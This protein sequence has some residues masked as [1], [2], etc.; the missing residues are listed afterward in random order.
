MRG[1]STNDR[2]KAA[3]WFKGSERQ[4]GDLTHESRKD[5]AFAGC[6]CEAAY[7]TWP[8]PVDCVHVG[9]Q[10]RRG[11]KKPLIMTNRIL[12]YEMESGWLRFSKDSGEGRT[13]LGRLVRA[14][15]NRALETG[16]YDPWD[17]PGGWQAIVATG[18][19]G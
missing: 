16:I 8:G 6:G 13:H 10:I 9:C 15:R 18:V 5:L 19:H 14:I 17:L 1:E 12:R 4:W 3:G 2:I 7:P 11:E